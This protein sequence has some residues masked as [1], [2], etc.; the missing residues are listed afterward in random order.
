[1]LS[2]SSA[3]W[4][5]FPVRKLAL[6]ASEVSSGVHVKRK[7]RDVSDIRM[8]SKDLHRELFRKSGRASSAAYRASIRDSLLQTVMS[9]SAFHVTK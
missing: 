1:M 2:I 9:Y 3:Y 7:R 4:I 5:L 6:E 8:S